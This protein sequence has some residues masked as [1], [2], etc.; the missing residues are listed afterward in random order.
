MLL[1]DVYSTD[2][3]IL[4]SVIDFVEKVNSEYHFGREVVMKSKH[5]SITRNEILSMAPRSLVNF[6]VWSV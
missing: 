1:I 6:E 4:V 3:K 5:N 2:V